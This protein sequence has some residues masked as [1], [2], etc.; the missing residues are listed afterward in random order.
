MNIITEKE[1]LGRIEDGINTLLNLSDEQFEQVIERLKPIR[2]EHEKKFDD[3]RFFYTTDGCEKPSNPIV[4]GLEDKNQSRYYYGGK[5]I[6]FSEL[7]K[8]LDLKKEEFSKD[9]KQY[10]RIERL[11]NNRNIQVYEN[12]LIEEYPKDKD[13]IKKIFNVLQNQEIFEKFLNFEKFAEEFHVKDETNIGSYLRYIGKIFGDIK[14]EFFFTYYD[15]YTA[16]YIPELPKIKDRVLQISE[17]YNLE[18]YYNRKY[19][20]EFVMP[21]DEVIRKGDEPEWSINSELEEAVFG[22][23]PN[24]L[25]LEEK[26]IYIYMKLCKEL[27][28]DEGYMYR[29]KIGPDSYSSEFSKEKQESIKPGSKVTCFEFSRICAKMI[30]QLEG[31]IEAVLV[32]QGNNK[33]HMFTGFY[34]DN[35][36][37]NLELTNNDPMNDITRAN[38]GMELRGISA[39]SDRKKILSEIKSK[40]SSLVIDEKRLS[41]D[42]YLKLLNEFPAQ[43]SDINFEEQ[44][45]LKVKLQSLLDTMKTRKITKNEFTQLLIEMKK[46]LF[47]DDEIQIANVGKKDGNSFKRMMLIRDKKS[48]EKIYKIHTEDLKLEECNFADIIDEMKSGEIVYEDTDHKIDGI[49]EVNV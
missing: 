4:F 41:I 23:M 38:A 44:N 1:K 14:K 11:K 18:R 37:V 5:G 29:D 46:S 16:F 30:N 36:S 19:Q 34:T 45:I 24:D 6:H 42:D 12:S 49:D 20:F 31:D 25:S 17:K 22:S 28:Y 2:K 26:A 32:L 9:S 33:G 35:V 21:Y 3:I 43:Q 47:K 8:K 48:K 40:I 7:L 27:V 15:I 10:Q 13:V 39:N